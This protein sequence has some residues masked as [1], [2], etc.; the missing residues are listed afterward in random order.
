MKTAYTILIFL[1][2][3][4]LSFSQN[5]EVIEKE[6][7]E[8]IWQPFKKS[9]EARDWN[10]FNS[11]HT[12]DVLR[13]NKYGIRIGEE[14]KTSVQTSYQKPTTKK[15]QID[16]CFNQRTYKES[17]GYEVGYY[18]V[19]YTEKDKEPRIVYG[20]FH[21]VLNKKNGVWLISQDWDTDTINGEPITKEDFESG[22][23]L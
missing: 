11:L 21:V 12:N 7:N 2:S 16:F 20:R 15:R 10:T 23:C 18:R 22:K 6:V 1:I 8:Q 4:T 5:K 19:I 14:Y 13:V 9:F 17:T 3:I